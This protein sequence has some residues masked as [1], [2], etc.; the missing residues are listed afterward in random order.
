MNVPPNELCQS[1]LILKTNNRTATTKTK[2]FP[3][4]RTMKNAQYPAAC[5]GEDRYVEWDAEFETWAVFGATSGHC[6]GQFSSEEQ[7]E[8][9]I[10]I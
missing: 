8:K 10:T 2:P 7:A 5:P 1:A 9:S 4:E 6:Y 3:G